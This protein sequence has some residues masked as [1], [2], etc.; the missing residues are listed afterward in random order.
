MNLLGSGMTRSKT[1]TGIVGGGLVLPVV[2]KCRKTSPK[3]RPLYGINQ[4]KALQSNL[5]QKTFPLPA[6]PIP[7]IWSFKSP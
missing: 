2:L 5:D 1:M 6:W 3:P 7:E 4:A